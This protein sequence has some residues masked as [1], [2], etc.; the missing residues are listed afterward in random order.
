MKSVFC[1]PLAFPALL[2]GIFI[3]S[4]LPPIFAE[5][6]PL[7]RAV[8]LALA[9]STTAGAASADEQRVFASYREARNQ[10]IPQLVVGSGL[11]KSWG[12]PLSLE[13]SAPSILNVNSQSTIFNPATRDFVRA[14]KTDW[15]AATVQTKDQKNQVIQDT[16][17]SYAELSKWETLA[18][19]LQDE[20]AAA[21]KAEQLVGERIKEGM[22][23]P[24]MQN[25]AH[26]STARLRL[27]LAEAQGAI[28]VIRNRLSHL[29][30]LPA[31][32]IDTAP[33]SM[34]PLPEVKQE[35]DLPGR[36]VRSS[37]A[38]Q[39]AENR[40]TA[41]G[42]RA[43]GE[44]RAM[45]PSADFAAQYGLLAR[46]NNY[47]EFF[48]T[49]Q[50]HNATIGVV[51]RF[52]F[53]SPSQHARAEA[54]DA[55]ALRAKKDAEAAKN[56]VSEETLRLQRLVEQMAAAQE[57]ADLEYRVAQSDLDSLQVRLDSGS[58]NWHEVQD[59]R[60]QSSER[61]NSLQD[62]NF[63]LERARITLLRATGDLENWI[64]VGK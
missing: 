59:A 1:H 17:L 3:G 30:G 15:N 22:D 7:K 12:F 5:P 43:R 28:D 37:P 29:T 35:D 40:A 45:L 39:A 26:L 11:G 21:I 46:Y 41:E 55:T 13:G 18:V 20:H 36:A 25:K 38:V 9:H 2:L 27:R 10:Y 24:L 52:P 49:F 4:A 58:A 61:Y 34:P 42:F 23:N 63:Q 50:R 19:H 56:Q 62:A 6:L 47:D 51:L 53:F 48:K 60:E 54:A 32:S 64:G 16:V 14:A 33:D 31:A 57:V 44:H 8:E